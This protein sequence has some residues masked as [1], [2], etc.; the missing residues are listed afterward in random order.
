[1]QILSH[2]QHGKQ[3]MSE[4]FRKKAS[5]PLLGLAGFI[6]LTLLIILAQGM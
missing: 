2:R 6:C 3:I 4:S 1:M 5:L